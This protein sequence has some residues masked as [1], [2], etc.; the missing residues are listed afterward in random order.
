MGY[1]LERERKTPVRFKAD[2]VVA[3]GG[4]A[5]LG[6]A[7]AAARNGAK[8]VLVERYGCLG[9]LATAGLVITIPPPPPKG[10]SGILKEIIDNL[11]RLGAAHRFR[12]GTGSAGIALF[13]PEML[14]LVA[15]QMV[16]RTGIKLLL[17][18]LVA[19]AVV[20]GNTLAGIIVEN[21][22]RRQA[23]SGKVVVDATGDGDAAAAAGAPYKIEKRKLL[24]VSLMYLVGGVDNDRVRKYEQSDPKLRRAASKAGFTHRAFWAVREEHQGPNFRH[25]DHIAK[26]QV[27]VGGGCAQADGT[28][29]ED[30]TRA[31]VELRK[32]A[33]FE[34]EFLKKN[35]PGFENA[36]LVATAPYI[37]V[38]ETR[39]IVGEYVL[40]ENDYRKEFRDAVGYYTCSAEP[41]QTYGIPYRCLLPKRVDNLL[42]AGRCFSA[43]HEVQNKLREIPACVAMGQA[44][45]TAAALSVKR[46]VK[47][48]RLNVKLLQ[49]SLMKQ[50]VLEK[51]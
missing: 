15:D 41:R 7:L 6:A 27:V 25:M 34:V 23:I 11:F 1:I 10:Y 42:V 49:K 9:G 29:V 4:P 8:T 13:D 40:K 2:V 46:G 36:H 16:E 19:D 22:S 43:T 28:D 30:L 17:G 24:P 32:R 21:K 5:G 3:G 50:G 48:R 44:A 12:K 18:S 33:R 14:K 37:G 45:G 51:A 38:R 26:G 20:K 39:R 35:V 31:E 47:P